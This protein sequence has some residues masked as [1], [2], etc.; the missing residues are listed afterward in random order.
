MSESGSFVGQN[1]VLATIRL[2]VAEDD[3]AKP[4]PAKPRLVAAKSAEPDGAALERLVLTP[5]QLV[6]AGVVPAGESARQDAVALCT[7]LAALQEPQRWEPPADVDAGSEIPEPQPAP[8]SSA[9]SH[10]ADPAAEP[11]A[12]PLVLDFAQRFVKQSANVGVPTE[13]PPAAAPET[14]PAPPETFPAPEQPKPAEADVA[15]I[16]DSERVKVMAEGW[17][18]DN[19]IEEAEI[20]PE[21]DG[22][23]A[24]SSKPADPTP[25]VAEA[26]APDADAAPPFRGLTDFE[27]AGDDG[28]DIL[29][30]ETLRDFVRDILRE[31]LQ[32]VFGER[33][34]RNVRKLVRTEIARMLQARKPD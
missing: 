1:D 30:E 5:M 11:V 19:V 24:A 18:Q 29:D 12:A 20:V 28:L 21:T 13:V 14:F 27:D 31:E 15:E 26:K 4:R 17:T 10:D 9:K 32:G 22:D 8:D 7:V 16:A 34:T 2:L 25:G 3:S 6:R 23:Q 33:I